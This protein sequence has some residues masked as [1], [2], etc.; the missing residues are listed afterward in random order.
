MSFQGQQ[1]KHIAKKLSILRLEKIF[2]YN[3]NP[4]LSW[5]TIHFCPKWQTDIVS[6]WEWYFKWKSSWFPKRI[7]VH[8]SHLYTSFT[9]WNLKKKK[10]F[11]AF[12]DF[13]QAS[14][15]AWRAG[16]W[17][18]LLQNNVDGKFF[19]VIKNMYNNVKSCIKLDGSC[20]PNF[21]A[22]MGVRQ[23][24]NL[25]PI[26]FSLFLNDLQSH[27]SSNGAVGA[28]LNES[29]DTT[30]WLE[31]LI[32]LYADDTVILSDNQ[33]DFQNS[34]NIFNT[35]C[36]NW[37]L[38]VNINKT[39]VIVFGARRTNLFNS[40]LGDKPI[41]ISTKYHYLGVTFSNNG[42]FLHARKHISEQANTALHYL[43]TKMNNSNLPLD[44]VLKLFDHTI[45]PILTYG[46]EDF[47]FE[48]LE[49]L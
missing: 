43:F 29:L 37:H 17:Y 5:Q 39:K 46:S 35:Y 4:Q 45:L 36:E 7:F 3:N 26:L 1:T 20:S 14:D 38:N 12:I 8:W 30:L 40:K 31:L 24:E 21:V 9:V 2:L 49:I 32:L 15:N 11:A 33:T 42:S 16:L 10:I 47:R 23:G 22:E 6:K 28:E 27:M 48:S 44:L 25:S 34:W 18:K 19:K 13:S 41:E